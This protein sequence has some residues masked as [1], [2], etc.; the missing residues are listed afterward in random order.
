MTPI[1]ERFEQLATQ[2]TEQVLLSG[3]DARLIL[4]PKTGVNKYGCGSRPDPGLIAFGSS[5]GSTI[6]A[7]GYAAAAAL[8]QH[9][10]H[11][12]NTLSESELYR[13]E[14][15]RIRLELNQLCGLSVHTDVAS[16]FAASGTDLHLICAQLVAGNLPGN[17]PDTPPLHIIMMEASETGSG[18]APAVRCQHFS[19]NAA[20]GGKVTAFGTIDGAHPIQVS[21]IGLRLP[22]GAKRPIA[23]IDLEVDKLVQISLAAHQRVLLI[24]IDVSK[25]GLIA[26]SPA[27]VA[28]LRQQYPE[29]I[30]V[31]IDAC[32]FRIA[33]TTLNAYLRLGCMVAL[34]G[35]K[36]LTG[37]V[38]S[39]VLLIPPNL[40][41]RLSR[42]RLPPALAGYSA[43]AEWPMH[44]HTRWQAARHLSEAINWGLLLR[45][46]AALAELRAFRA[47]P[48][49]DIVQFLTQ[50][51]NTMQAAINGSPHFELMAE[52]K[53][54]R[55]PISTESSWDQTPTIFPFL[56]LH[57]PGVPI[58]REQTQLIY[59]QL[60][61]PIPHRP[62][63]TI[64]PHLAAL[65]CQLGQPVL[66]G[67]QYGQDVSALRMCA[68]SRVIIE[69]CENGTT[70]I[71]V[72]IRRALSV[73]EKA[74][75]LIQNL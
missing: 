69:A 25:T 54:S 30:D 22:N 15:E 74:A 51:S 70:S 4:D 7:R 24:M 64:A 65:R 55:A 8:H 31:L 58:T 26:P 21:S 56:L 13:H 33:N 27:Y 61:F 29:Q 11:E 43:Q 41:P 50:F 72:V 40:I 67:H 59:K 35:S 52:S 44:K 39:G 68:S 60:Q 18:V 12:D 3:G 19:D 42:Q 62:G 23:D 28:S 34:T 45:L 36:F 75:Y 38:F 2:S 17:H 73:F 6:S 49:A 32:Q 10:L 48:E 20:L 16:V 66:C 71:D 53:L 5:T 1:M 14:L 63:D 37:P 57:R 47:I 46:E 9:L